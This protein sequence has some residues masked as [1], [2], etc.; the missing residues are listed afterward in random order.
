M[1][2]LDCFA[3]DGLPLPLT[4]DQDK[5]AG[6]EGLKAGSDIENVS[7]IGASDL[8]KMACAEVRQGELLLFEDATHFLF[9]FGWSKVKRIHWLAKTPAML[10]NGLE[11]SRPASSRILLDEPRPQLAGSAPSS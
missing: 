9:K 4:L 10:P 2:E 1:E 6:P 11:M 7:A 3:L 5:E 8:L